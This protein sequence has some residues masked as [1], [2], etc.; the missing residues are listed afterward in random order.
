MT[1]VKLQLRHAPV[2][3]VAQ[4]HRVLNKTTHKEKRSR[5]A[6][7]IMRDQMDVMC[8]KSVG[9]D[10]SMLDI[11]DLMT[12]ISQL[13]KEVALLESKLRQR[14][15]LNTKDVSGVCLCGF[16]DQTSTELLVSV[17]NDEDQKT[18]VNLLDCGTKVKQ[19]VTEEQIDEGGLIFS[20]LM[21]VKQ[22][23]T[24]AREQTNEDLKVKEESS[25][26][27][28]MEET[29]HHFIPKEESL[30]CLK[31]KKKISPK[32]S[33][34]QKTTTAKDP[35]MCPQCRFIFS[36]KSALK[37][38]M[39][40]HTGEKPHI[41]VQCGKSFS[42][43]SYLTVHMKI[44]TGEK[45]F[46]CDQCG[47]S[48]PFKSK[49]NIHTRIHTG[50]KPYRCEWCEKS[51]AR[52]CDLNVHKRNHTGD[53]PYRCDQC[54]K[55]FV[56]KSDLNSHV[57]I[58]IGEKPHSCDRCGKAFI[59]KCQLNEHMKVHTGEKPLRCDQ[60]GKSFSR[61]SNLNVHM[62]IHTGEKA[63]RCVISVEKASV[64]SPT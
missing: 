6:M 22:E 58:H 62:K 55:G 12:E 17:C 33:N 64:E 26:L 2:Q 56:R 11:D 28:I 34:K 46:N 35:F 41:C 54:G 42:I 15:E 36:H 38:H 29:P 39:N 50:D 23:V 31:T 4:T 49:L 3:Q 1:V 18:S 27:S 5:A 37:R 10:L 48:F 57:K 52:R 59:H 16:A 21:E 43:R 63:Y 7:F 25:Q 8:C 13:K 40:L 24:E 61:K 47:K 9:T 51:F 53:K 30:T 19:E 14:D 45:P 20:D 60:C 32:I 44:H